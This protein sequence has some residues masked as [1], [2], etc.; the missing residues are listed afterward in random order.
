MKNNLARSLQVGSVSWRWFSVLIVLIAALIVTGCSF[1]HKENQSPAPETNH[2]PDHRPMT[3]N[4][5]SNPAEAAAISI[6]TAPPPGPAPDGMVWVPGGTF[7]MGCEDCE[8]PDATP[9][10][11]VT[12]DG[13]WMDKTPVTNAQFARFVKATGYKTIAER[14][15]D[16]K[17]F[18][19][20]DPKNLVPGAIVFTPPPNPVP[21]DNAYLWWRYLP[22]ASWKHPEGPNSNFKGREDHPAVQIAWD[23]AT[24]Y[25]QWAGRRLPTE[26]EFEFA[27]RG[28]ADQ[29]HFAWGDELQPGGKW[30]ANIWQGRFPSHNSGE[31]GFMSTSPVTAFPPNAYGLYD[32]AGNVWQWCA[33][34]Y[35]PDYYQQLAANGIARNPPGPGDSLDPDEPGIAKRIQRSG[36][37]LC[38]AQY[39]SRYLVG[40]RGK[41]AA[42]SGGSNTGFRCVKTA[43]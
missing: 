9:V 37:F 32:I 10:H 15:P 3:G 27:A 18:P 36:S 35:R 39:C 24:A 23:D 8:M 30:P 17:D 28:G 40:S 12:V 1:R 22:G 38:S 41:G 43:F 19:G 14:Q 31:D 7:R 21:L 13:F 29:K 6:N 4:S 25:A 34:W 20:A 26:A 33:D 42:D 16:P 5:T 11:L 2:H